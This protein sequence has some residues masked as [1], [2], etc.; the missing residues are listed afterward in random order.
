MYTIVE[1]MFKGDSHWTMF[2][3]GGI[4]YILVGGINS[5]TRN[6]P[7]SVQMAVSAVIITALEF[8]TGC[9]VNLWLDFNVW[10]YGGLPFNLFGQICPLFTFLWYWLSA[11]GIFA[12]DFMRTKMFCE[13]KME[14]RII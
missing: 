10:D 1:I 8:V 6:M 7:L 4:C 11:V 3:L 12:D 2:I 14:Y 9:I 13:P 5:I